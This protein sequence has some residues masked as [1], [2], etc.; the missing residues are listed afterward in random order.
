MAD[1]IKIDS[2]KDL[3]YYIN[4]Y[5]EDRLLS[6][7]KKKKDKKM[8]NIAY[9]I[10][11]PTE[12]EHHRDVETI[13]KDIRRLQHEYDVDRDILKKWEAISLRKKISKLEKE[14]ED[15]KA[16]EKEKMNRIKNESLTEVENKAVETVSP[17]YAAAIRDFHK[18]AKVREETTKA[19]EA[20]KH[21][22]KPATPKMVPG[23]KKL[24]LDESLFESVESDLVDE[25][26]Y[27]YGIS[28]AEAR[29]RFANTLKDRRASEKTLDALKGVRK[30]NAKAEIETESCERKKNFKEGINALGRERPDTYKKRGKVVPKSIRIYDDLERLGFDVYADTREG[31]H[32][33]YI[34]SRDENALTPAKNYLDKNEVPYIEKELLGRHYVNITVP[35]DSAQVDAYFKMSDAAERERA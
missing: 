33:Y 29:K 13:E 17:A 31:S 12:Q 6:Y 11:H 14:L 30:S 20:P 21:E 18:S 10:I 16:W 8:Y 19:Q 35:E 25:V 26:S 5:G 28:K 4:E 2:M 23:A 15:A 3:V 7:L 24:H 9:G 1:P 27:Q 34:S 32:G 22:E